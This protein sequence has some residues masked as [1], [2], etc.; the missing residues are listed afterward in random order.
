[1][2]T[3]DLTNPT[4][5]AVYINGTA[6]RSVATY[7][8]S[9]GFKLTGVSTRTCVLGSGWSD[10]APTC[11]AGKIWLILVIFITLPFINDF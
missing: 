5:G 1:M 10:V 2:F 7:T 9:S 4:N 3:G 8:C 6:L 11:V